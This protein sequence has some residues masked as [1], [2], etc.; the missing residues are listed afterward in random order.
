MNQDASS[1]LEIPRSALLAVNRALT[2]IHSAVGLRPTLEAIA[3]G[4]TVST[5]YQDVAVTIAEERNAAELRVIAVIGPPDA[6]AL[7]LNTTCRRTA[8]LEHLAGGEAWGSLRFLAAAETADGIISYRSEYEPLA[9]PDAWRPD[10]ELVAPLSAPDGELI[11]MLSMDRPRD[12]RIPPAWVNDVLELFAEQASIAIL[13][14]RRHEQAV[15]AMQALEREKAELHSAVAEQSARETHLRRQARSDP[16]TGLANRVML[17]ERLLELLTAQT[18]VAV[19]FCDL[20][21]FKHIND[22]HGHAIGDEVLRVIG[23][24]LAQHLA[25]A[26]VV[27][28]IGGDEFVVVISGTDPADSALLLQRIDRAVAGEPVYAGGLCLEVTSSL[29]L[30]REPEQPER[31][32]APVRR[33]EEVLSRADRE[34]Y[35]HKRSR[36]A[37]SRLLTRAEARL[38]QG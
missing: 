20:D 9:G 33:V 8:L 6:V 4:V 15:R 25:D 11:G 26:D 17:Q 13:N 28:R 2:T 23:R 32:L 38:D 31:R 27:A 5:P 10:Y 34:M 14:A 30:I 35:A 37:M 18:P 7:L 19:V 16:L 24:R 22:E 36:A 3:H 21:H 12:G 1:K 29:G